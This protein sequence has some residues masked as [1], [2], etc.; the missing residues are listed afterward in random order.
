M[1]L[2]ASVLKSV[3]MLILVHQGEEFYRETVSRDAVTIDI[4]DYNVVS[5]IYA[6]MHA[7]LKLLP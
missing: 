2:R 1:S 4:R 6:V 7:D 3:R 5:N